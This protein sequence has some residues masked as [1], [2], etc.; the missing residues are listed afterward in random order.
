MLEEARREFPNSTE[1]DFNLRLDYYSK[2]STEVLRI[3]DDVFG[4]NKE[5]VIGVI[6]PQGAFRL[7]GERMLQYAWTDNPLSNK[8]YGIDAIGIAP[9]F[10]NYLGQPESQ[11]ELLSWTNDADGGLS[12]LFDEI[13]Q[14]GVLKS[15]FPYPGG[16]LKQS[17]DWIESY[18]QLAQ[19]KDL[20]LLGSE[21]GQS[22]RG[23]RGTENNDIINNLFLKANRDERMKDV[24][25]QYF[26]KW[27]ELGGDI[28]A[29]FNDVGR[30]DRFSNFGALEH[31][32]QPGSPKYDALL[33][34]LAP[35]T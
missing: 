26:Q 10:G 20:L 14:G 11:Q 33:E 18:A 17:Y 15:G 16:A 30:Y 29:H 13:T 9:Y 12:K 23:Y 4:A 34:L 21:A 22:I 24:Y 31:I 8:E 35:T 25:K 3:W 28:V 7:T 5:R 32:N 19:Q 27:H 2:R 1:N 6:G